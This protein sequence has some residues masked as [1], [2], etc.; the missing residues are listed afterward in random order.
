M[1]VAAKIL[2]QLSE[3]AGFVDSNPISL[4]GELLDTTTR[5]EEF[6]ATEDWC[7]LLKKMLALATTV[8]KHIESLEDIQVVQLKAREIDEM[9]FAGRA[10]TTT[11]LLQVWLDYASILLRCADRSLVGEKTACDALRAECDLA[12]NELKSRADADR[13]FETFA[14][15]HPIPAE[16]NKDLVER[17]MEAMTRGEGIDARDYLASLPR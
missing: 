13:A 4:R 1:I 7:N 12:E 15:K 16:W 6:V 9:E 2:D 11:A 5:N 3:I 8:R 14:A 17:N 10:K